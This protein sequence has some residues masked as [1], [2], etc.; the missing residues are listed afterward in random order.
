MTFFQTKNIIKRNI[1][2]SYC[3]I[4]TFF[5]YCSLKNLFNIVLF[6]NFIYFLF[7]E[8]DAL[9]RQIVD[10]ERSCTVY[11]TELE[12]K[13]EQMEMIRNQVGVLTE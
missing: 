3:K 6:L 8:R 9:E 1:N 12:G 11:K 4:I 10:L 2:F 7:S 13:T 5:Y